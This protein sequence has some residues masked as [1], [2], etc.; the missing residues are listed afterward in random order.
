MDSRAG[1]SSARLSW[2]HVSVYDS[3][4]K[5]MLEVKRE[6]QSSGDSA[7]ECRFCESPLTAANRVPDPPSPAL[8]NVC[9]DELCQA[10]MNASCTRLLE[11][12]HACGGVRGEEACLPCL[13]GCDQAV[14]VDPEE[15]VTSTARRPVVCHCTCGSR[16]AHM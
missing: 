2:V 12:G 8:A 10:A 14:H 13:H 4:G 9:T 15:C 1:S 3:K 7:N 6:G 11:C 16:V 5:A